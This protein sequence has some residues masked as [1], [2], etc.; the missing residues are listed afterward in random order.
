MPAPLPTALR[1]R[2]VDAWQNGEGSYRELASRFTVGEASVS[3]L[4]RRFRETG[5]VEPKPM[6][7]RHRSRL[8]DA[9]GETFIKDTLVA[10]PDS[11]LV[12]LSEAFEEEFG[13]VV[14]PQRMSELLRRLGL[15][16]KRG[17][18]VHVPLNGRMSSKPAR[19][20]ER[21]CPT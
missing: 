19:P 1:R 4:L 2:I 7:G 8:V 5:S 18:S 3:R 11:T 6:G 9:E 13:K 12:E 21:T 17:S 20:T 10:Q 14:S 15:T 16:R